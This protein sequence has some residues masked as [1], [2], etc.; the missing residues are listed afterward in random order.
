MKSMSVGIAS[1]L[2][3]RLRLAR[4]SVFLSALALGSTAAFAQL[5]V[6]T[7]AGSGSAGSTNGTGTAA[8]FQFSVP[9]AVASDA[10]G[11]LYI[12]DAG[13][14]VIRKVT[15]AGVVTT[16]AGTAG[17]PG[18]V[19][20]TGAAARFKNPRGIAIDGA[21][22]L[23]VADS[24]NHIIRKIDTSAVVTT[25]AGTADTPGSVDGTGAAARFN[26]PFGIASERNGTAV[27]INVYVADSQNHTIRQ[28]VVST[29]VV[30]TLAGSAGASGFV[31]GTGNAARFNQPSG[32]IANSTGSTLYIADRFNHAIRQLVPSTGAVTTLAGSGAVGQLD[33]T[34]SSASFNNPS[35]VTL[36]SSGNILVSDTFN[37][38]IRSVTP[39]GVVATLAGAAAT[40]GN[41]N[42]LASNARFNFPSGIT[43][44]GANTYVIDTNNQLVRQI[45]A[46]T[47]P[48]IT[49]QPTAASGAVGSSVNFTVQATG[50]PPV[51]YQWQVQ[52]GGVG[53]FT[54]LAASATYS[55]VTG[56]QLTVN[57][58]TAAMNGD[59]FQVV[60]SN[61]VGSPATSSAAALTV[62][63]PPV[64]TSATSANFPVGQTTQFT[65]TATGSP[66][67][68]LSVTGLPS[69]GWLSFNTATGV[70][71]GAPTNTDA[72]ATLTFTASNSVSSV[73]QTFTASVVT[74]SVP[75]LTGPSAQSVAA[76]GTSA[77]FSVSATGAPN[78]FTYQW[79]RSTTGTA[80][81]FTALTDG[82][83]DGATYSGSTTATL[84]INGVTP[85]MNGYAYRVVVT[86]AP[87]SSTTS[88]AALLNVAPL[89]VS[90]PSATFVN[91]Q[92]GSFTFQANG[93]PTPTITVSVSGTLPDGITFSS[94]TLSGTPTSTVSS[95][96]FIQVVATNSG[97]THVQ[98]FTLNVAPPQ[99]PQ[100]TSTANATFSVGQLG[101]FTFTASGA[102]TP[103]I[104]VF[105]SLPNGVSY[106][107]QTG[108]LSGTPLAADGS[109]FLL[110]V[111]ASNS[112]GA[113]AV[114]SFT[115]TVLGVAPT[116]T[117]HPTTVTANVGQS[118][119][120][121]AAA[122]GSPTPT[123]RW[124]RQP[125]G[126]S[127]F[128]NLSDDGVYSGT[129]TT[130]LTINAVT[131][132]M[133]LDQFRLVASNGT[134]PEATSSSAEL[135][136][137]LGTVISTIAGQAG[138][139]GGAN[140]TG[141]DARF[142]MPAGIASDGFGNLYIA[143]SA[144]HVI[145]R[146]TAA[147]AVTTFAG[148]PG[149]AGSTDGTTA[150]ARFNSPQGVALDGAGNVY[151]ADTGNHV[152]RVISP[153]GTVST[154][155][156]AAASP[157]SID[158]I[159][160]S[161][162]FFA[163]AG[164]A[165]D[166]VGT[167]YVSDTSNH[168]IRRIATDGV[169]TTY[170]GSP[171]SAAHFD[172]TGSIARF[173]TPVGLAIDGF[174]NL[175]VADSFNHVIRKITAGANVTTLAGLANNAGITDGTGV[176]ARFNRPMAIA[177]DT[178]GNV[179]VADTFSSTIRKVTAA[180]DVTT[181]AGHAGA[182]GS[183]DGSGSAARFNQP[184]GIAV[185]FASNVYIADTRNHTIRRSGLATAAQF[186]TQPTNR[187]AAAGQQV[188][189]TATATGSPQPGYQWQRASA[190]SFG[191]F[192]NLA[193][194]GIYSG[195]NTATL[196]INGVTDAMNGDQ[197]RVIANNGVAPVTSETVTLTVGSA[198]TITSAATAEFRA[199]TAGRFVVT[200]SSATPVTFSATNLPSWATIN[201]STGEITGT[202]P[203]T[204]GSPFVVTV[205][206]ANP[207][208]ATQSL[209]ITVAPA[210]QPPTITSQPVSTTVDAGQNASFSVTV[211]GSEPFT[212]QWRKDGISILGATSST[213]VLANVQAVNTGTY[214]VAISNA[215]GAIASNGATLTVNAAPVFTS[216]PRTQIAVTGTTV[217]FSVSAIGP[218][219][220]YQWRRNGAPIS[221]ANSSTFTLANATVA[222]AGNYDVV[223]SNPYGLFN[224]SLAQL[225]IVS[226]PTAPLIT[227]QPP[228]RTV[229]VG[230]QLTLTIAATG[231]PTPT[232][233]WRKNGAAI[234]GANG[235]SYAIGSVQQSD[236]GA[237]DVVVS[238]SAG[239]TVSNAGQLTVITRSYA[240]I[241]F[242][243][244][245]SALG[246]F[247][248]Y[249]RDDNTG[250]FLG[251]IPGSNA[252][253]MSFN[254]LVNDSGQFSFSQ[255][256]IASAPASEAGGEPGR[257][258]ALA[259]VGVSG[260]IQSDG[261]ISG[262]MSGGANASLSGS[263]SALAGPTQNVAGFYQ[264]G[265]T[266]SAAAA[267]TIAGANGTA[268][269]VA[270]S[271]TTSDG[272][273]GTVASSGQVNVLTG[274]SI[275]SEVIFASAGVISG[276]SSG[277]VAATFSGGSDSAVA[278]QR[279]VNISSRARVT[280]GD[281]VA[282]AG[283]VIAGV[284]SK[285]VLIRAVG[286]T[287]GRAPFN[288]AGVLTTPRLELFR[289]NTSLAI[290]TGIGTNRTAI[291]AAGVLAGAFTLG[292]DGT[293]A[294]ILTTLSPGNYTAVVGSTT[295]ATGV[296]LIEV[297]D[298]SAPTP[299]QKLLNI[300]TRATAG[301][302]ENTLI[303]GF[304]IPPGTAKRVLVRGIGPG[305][306]PLGVSGVLPA[307]M[308]TL[309]SGNG[310]IAQNSNWSTS[311]DAAAISAASVQVGAFT[312]ANADA[313]LIVTLAPGNYTAQVTGA[314]NATGV[315]LI[316]V[317]ELP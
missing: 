7:L 72:N 139:L 194:D 55:G 15:P 286:P 217:N 245:S 134:P 259:A 12:A 296:A 133:G 239:S 25:I 89:I 95:S 52:P 276:N 288:V 310:T 76:G 189:F 159:G 172:S 3:P 124:Q 80:G 96:T 84:T 129:T 73:N 119:V 48:S 68:T 42:G 106:N 75:Q 210:L 173:N 90:Q 231:A 168:T 33:S 230:T 5:A 309:V 59:R 281:A 294:A 195:V 182:T 98:N 70:L 144:N 19:D 221:G 66:T 207:V 49:T 290:N 185:D 9:S 190:G 138:F 287:L 224:S 163:P 186:Q 298:L 2:K 188:S 112:V 26:T 251:Y 214:S 104:Q 120:F 226:T 114:Q 284:E 203:D 200:A 63:Q 146:M 273:R 18:A 51:S 141:P 213:L 37:H 128:S 177:V 137:N 148:V 110:T 209:T 274:R 279:L 131:P 314:N 256:A 204:A 244:F 107:Q 154:R 289:G 121:T 29:G 71:T 6:S 10:S 166:N 269:V 115:L 242:G 291:D 238:N 250:V 176:A 247:A 285:P 132:S 82:V 81:S 271:G 35:G 255:A 30:T 282:I 280:S 94:P 64:F 234:T 222:D 199:G 83:V 11:N 304:V 202:P 158:G 130:T 174:G 101:S 301:T 79:E 152:V 88:T 241:Y 187:V 118:A 283:F 156:G 157:G 86:N 105:G 218:G 277:A 8:S 92:F 171:G 116:I 212:Y 28:I 44:S 61:G 216:Q 252:P 229:L 312:M 264:A 108:I 136:V 167:I 43:T 69:S 40:S 249:I 93:T 87:S 302:N 91:N 45:S 74:T 117:T 206:V 243:S 24:G 227:A 65:V 192:V 228:N 313:A 125:A 315:A 293:D 13:N 261:S 270:Q 258:A 135:R 153:V 179:Y 191:V 306:T 126:T 193:N 22:N 169:V 275:I 311:T 39:A 164:I 60:V 113:S 198:P 208:L 297:Y 292:A 307:P 305:L 162:R 145:R 272:G 58:L 299:G 143:D 20:A 160:A 67:P 248:M 253:V 57:N 4:L 99:A 170:A 85:A 236:A 225:T 300:S 21:G 109:P 237:Y 38:T 155:A 36:D 149:F 232:Y 54:N 142:Y 223:V 219:I 46:A 266:G 178:A 31:N 140:G 211:S 180:G 34:G 265:A 246:E 205:T 254:V 262:S 183:L 62:T 103:T 303:A 240:G 56:N 267:Y 175:Y 1:L 150:E 263:R 16:F 257:A 233:Q 14:H 100:I 127:G 97:G 220:T 122:A 196:T 181:L 161:A 165:V 41:A 47:A 17:S 32:I 235:P 50:N 184:Q 77:S 123:L 201:P 111:Q 147:G 197:F 260:T 53:S 268:F 278:N 23:Y 316:E 295:T 27:A 308:L 151:V 78:T 317:Y 102:P 215:A